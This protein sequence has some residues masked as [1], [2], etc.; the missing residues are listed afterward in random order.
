LVGW[1]KEIGEG[2]RRRDEKE[3]KEGKLRNGWWETW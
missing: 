2:N 1:L 3:P